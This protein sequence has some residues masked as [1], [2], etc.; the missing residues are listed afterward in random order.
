MNLAPIEIG[1]IGMGVLIFLIFIRMPIGLA[2]L[3]VGAGG[4]AAINGIYP[5]IALLQNV[6]YETFIQ[7]SYCVVPLFILMGNFAFKSGLSNDLYW[8]VHKM[9]GSLKGGLAMA[10]VGACGAFAAICGSSVA[11]AITMGVV[12]LPEMKKF[13]YSDALATGAIA[14]GGTL[15]I[16]IPPSTIM[17]I[18]GIITQQSI[19]TLFMAGFI[20]GILQMLLYIATIAFLVKRNPSLG[21]AGTPCS[22]G[23]KIRA[24]SKVWGVVLLFALV[25]GGLYAGIFSPNEAAGIGAFAAMLLG[26]LYTKMPKKEF[27]STCMDAAVKS[28]GIGFLIMVGAM[29]F[30]YFLAVSRVPFVMADSISALN[31]PT[32]VVI[33][34]ILFILIALGCFMDSMAIVLLTV[35]IFFPLVQQ[36]NID[37]IWFGIL[38]VRVTEMGLITPPVGLNL[39]VIKGVADVPMSS[40]FRGAVP[41]IIADF[42]HLSILIAFPQITL[43][44]PSL[45]M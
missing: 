31:A 4:F 24:L 37:P 2:M 6:P 44:L 26:F 35:P 18:Y 19:G 40:V 22:M 21:P 16:L 43:F 17:V 8:A 20:P 36:M 25:I 38:V 27:V 7:Y 23:E 12:A 34:G 32:L 3:L 42:I 29:V 5:A 11:T 45:L 33:I 1:Y 28:T 14:A 39:F 13:K 10:T 41:F 15:G 9:M 30:G